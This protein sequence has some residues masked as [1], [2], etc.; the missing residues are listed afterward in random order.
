[1]IPKI[2]HYCWFGGSPLPPLA[3]KCIDS[4]KTHCAD[5]QIIEWNENNF[6][7]NINRYSREA[8]EVNQWAF[9]SD[10]ARLYIVYTYG[11]VYLD[12]DVEVL[13]SIDR[14]L[15][16]DMFMGFESFYNIATGLGFG[17]KKNFYL[18]K[19]MLD[20]YDEI[21]F[22]N[23]DGTLNRTPCPLYT[24]E[25]MRKEGFTINNQKQTLKGVNVYP[26]EYFCPKVSYTGDIYITSNTHTIHHFLA[27]WWSD[28]EKKQHESDMRF[29]RTAKRFRRANQN[30]DT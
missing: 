7:V 2:I 15:K 26:S 17:A 11:G 3:V 13:K 19:K 5:Y 8:A 22:I 6:D 1:M 14:F 20:E 27:S 25:T 23:A 28:E 21:S 16:D 29:N 24:T 10:V 4:W 9:V 30:K 18:L 12:V